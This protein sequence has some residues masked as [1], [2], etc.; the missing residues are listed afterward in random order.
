[1]HHTEGCARPQCCVGPPADLAVVAL[2]D[3]APRCAAAM[4]SYRKTAAAYESGAVG[5]ELCEVTV[6]GGRGKPDKALGKDEEY[7]NVNFDKFTSLRTIFEVG[8][9]PASHVDRVYI[10]VVRH[11]PCFSPNLNQTSPPSETQCAPI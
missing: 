9:S 11:M 4:D 2:S 3:A 7:T 6:P 8:H 5:A 10:N 1:M